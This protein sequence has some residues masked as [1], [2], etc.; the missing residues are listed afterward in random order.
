MTHPGD[1]AGAD[2]PYTSL[3]PT[4]PAELVPWLRALPVGSVLLDR[5]TDAWQTR[6]ANGDGPIIISCVTGGKSTYLEDKYAADYLAEWAPF[7]LA[8][9]A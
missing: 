9:K 3:S 8:W 6:Q 1:L 4:D 7:L 5:R 2:V